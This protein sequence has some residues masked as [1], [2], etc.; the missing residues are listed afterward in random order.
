[1]QND[2]PFGRLLPLR[3]GVIMAD[4]PW[5][6]EQ[7]SK[8]ITERS[9]NAA[10]KYDT[11]TVEDICKLPVSHLGQRDCALMMWGT[12]PNLRDVIRVM[13][14]WGFTFKGKCFAWAKLNSLAESH[15]EK[16]GRRIDDQR[17]WFMGNGYSSRKNTEDCWLGTIGNPKR[18][19]ASVRELIVAPVREHS[20]KP[21]EA[22]DRAR[23]LYDGPHLELFSRQYRKGWDTWGDEVGK[24]QEA[25]E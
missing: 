9:R 16:G 15:N 3:Y 10:A 7:F 14:A 22:Y 8:H 11:M 5:R 24:F 13:D 6:F 2:W 4:P 23:Q 1:M 25:A 19:S 20:R 17:N 18:L 12:S 21:D